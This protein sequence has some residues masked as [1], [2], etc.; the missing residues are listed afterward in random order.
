[1]AVDS[2]NYLSVGQLT[3][4]L[5]AK[6]DRDPYLKKVYL[7]GQVSNYRKRSNGHQYFSLKDEEAVISAMMFKSTFQKLD[8][9]LEEGMQVY[10]IGRLGLYEKHGSYQIYIDQLI[11][12]GKGALQVR[13]EQL[14]AR[15]IKEGIFDFT[16]KAIPR[17]PKRIAVVTSASGAVIRDIETTIRRRYPIVQ[18]DLYPTVVQGDKSAADIVKNLTRVEAD[19]QYDLVIVGRGGGSIEDLWPF[20]EEAVVYQIAKMQTPVISSVGHETDTTLTDFVADVRAATPTAAAEI[21]TP[22]LV[23]EIQKIN[24]ARQNLT[25]LMVQRLTAYRKRLDYVRAS[26]VLA[27]PQSLYDAHRQRLA[28]ADYSLQTSQE[29]YLKTSQQALNNQQAKLAGANPQLLIAE[30]KRQLSLHDQGLQQAQARYLDQLGQQVKQLIV[31]LDLLSPLK[32]LS[33][34]YVYLSKAGNKID[35]IND[36]AKGDQVTIQLKDGQATGQILSSHHQQLRED[37]K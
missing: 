37:D 1:M 13:Y 8:F 7:T 36:L 33:Q 25:S 21:A 22:V 23:E 9:E 16:P 6:F 2:K 19:G 4:Y 18:V 3:R 32:R 12:D 11:P 34:G 27:K 10:A 5:K 29:A 31:S 20:N 24:Q 14:K 15:L 26:N 35:T 30:A 28:M 17:F